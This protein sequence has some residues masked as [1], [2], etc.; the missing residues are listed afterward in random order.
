VTI[1]HI[2]SISGGKDSEA[3]AA[4]ALHSVDPVVPR[5]DLSF[6]FADTGNE[7]RLTYD[8]ID[9]LETV[10]GPIKRLKANFDRQIEGKRKFV[11][12]HWAAKGV[13]Q[14]VI[15]RAAAALKPSGNPYLD[16]CLWKGR[17]P[18]RK[19]QFCTQFLKTE[20]LVEYQL[21]FIDAGHAVW[22]WQ[23]VRR[24]ESQSRRYAA[25]FED[26]GGGLYIYR[27]I[28]RWRASDCFDAMELAG[29]KWNPLYAMG[30]TRVGCMPCINAAKDEILEIA[31]RFPEEIDRIAEWEVCVS[32]AAKRGESSFFPNPDRDAHLDKRGVYKVVS[33]ASTSRGGI[34]RDLF[35]TAVAQEGPSCSSS[36]G[37]CE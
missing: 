10:L 36:Y 2:V 26:V 35:R 3:T 24:D 13:P 28:A 6:V 29:M 11:L 25:E 1:K 31:R 34:Q 8:H 5:E 37:L 12:E 23:G 20:P 19:A 4:L 9:Y 32:L 22:S 33:W 7:H 16:L 18:S 21:D 30:M 14:A 15:D 27:P 17:F